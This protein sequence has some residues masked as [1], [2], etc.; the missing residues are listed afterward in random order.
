MTIGQRLPS[1]NLASVCQI[2]IPV[3]AETTT[4]VTHTLCKPL[5]AAASCAAL[6]LCRDP[7]R[8]ISRAPDLSLL[9][10]SW[11]TMAPFHCPDALW[12]GECPLLLTT[13][14]V[15]PLFCQQLFSPVL[16]LEGKFSGCDSDSVSPPLQA[17]DTQ[18]SPMTDERKLHFKLRKL[19][20]PTPEQGSINSLGN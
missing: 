6:S 8:L 2:N 20:G 11:R 16:C 12:T 15:V 9:A 10:L 18:H 19:H 17:D 1:V 13:P 14:D 4:S 5:C 7:R 3:T